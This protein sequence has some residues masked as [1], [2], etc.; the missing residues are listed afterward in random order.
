MKTSL[1]NFYK[2]H[3]ELKKFNKNISDKKLLLLIYDDKYY[4]YLEKD[5]FIEYDNDE[6]SMLNIVNTIS[7]TFKIDVIN[8]YPICFC[9][10]TVVV[11]FRIKTDTSSSLNRLPIDEIPDKYKEI[12]EY[13]RNSFEMFYFSSTVMEEIKMSRKNQLR[14]KFH[15]NVIKKYILTEKKRKKEE[16]NKLLEDNIPEYKTAIDVSCGDSRDLFKVAKKKKYD[17]VV[18]NDICINYLYKNNDDNVIYTNDDIEYNFVKKN[19][20]D[21]V[22][23]KNTLHHMKNLININ[24]L[25]KYLDNISSKEILIVE[26][27][28]PKEIGGLPAF[29]NKWLYVK[30]LKDVGDCFLNKNQFIKTIENNYKD[31]DIKFDEF[32]NILGKYM[33]A[34]IKKGK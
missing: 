14:Y 8:Y 22:F 18:G 24:N 27:I 28:N 26:I 6:D 34:R 10:K 33:V 17:V 1:Y 13:H 19:S 32:E 12:V 15:E 9:N 5:K 11:G 21:L 2:K 30:F 3:Y 4:Y 7:K 23:C 31:Y 20:Y 25:L 16:F 29:L